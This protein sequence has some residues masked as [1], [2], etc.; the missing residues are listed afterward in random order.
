MAN[1]DKI[2]RR[3]GDLKTARANHEN[4][5]DILAPYT[6]PTRLGVLS[7]QVNNGQ[8]QVEDIYDGTGHFAG[9]IFANFVAGEIFNPARK[10]LGLRERRDELNEMDDVR[11]WLEECRD[12]M[13]AEYLRSNF[14]AEAPEAVLDWG[15][16]G[17]GSLFFDE[18]QQPENKVVQGF[19]GIRFHAD[20]TG[21]FYIAEDS[22]GRVDTNYREFKLS[23]RAAVEKFGRDNVSDGIQSA[24]QNS[25]DRLFDFIHAVEPRMTGEQSRYKGAKGM[26][27]QSCFVE[28]DTKKIVEESGYHEFPSLNP[29]YAKTPGE[30]Y[31]RGL[32]ELALHDMQTLNADVKMGLEEHALVVRPPILVRHDAVFST[33]RLWPAGVTK[34]RTS[35][36]IQDA[37]Q[38][39][40]SGGNYQA[41]QI[42]KGDLRKMIRQVFMVD[43]ILQMLEVEKTQMTA[44]EWRGKMNLLYRLLG[45]VYGRFVSEFLNP[46]VDRTF[47]LMLRGGAFSDPPDAIKEF[48]GVIDAEYDNPLARAQKE[49]EVQAI[50][51]GVQ[52]LA[53]IAKM[54]LETKG[55]TQAMDILDSDKAAKKIFEVRGV[56]A[57]VTRSDDEIEKIR[58]ARQQAQQEEQAKQDAMAVA[59]GAGKVAPF[60]KAAQGINSAGAIQPKAA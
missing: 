19:R 44:E 58:S 27:W 60:V 21:R 46:L 18:D 39:Y 26:P 2:V 4:R 41:D 55:S 29:R 50:Q 11:E 1:G 15:V 43:Q 40:K 10:W 9:T 48:G 47:N 37:Y 32:G 38:A 22:Q 45:P 49:E 12:R 14:Y 36:A 31:G 24:M 35:G 17:T 5:W 30:I 20:K 54:E 3:F 53:L 56:P 25:M 59:E 13:C 51:A 6:A 8:D 57:S 16:F 34:L 28:K 52:D 42:V 7:N 33:L 23:A